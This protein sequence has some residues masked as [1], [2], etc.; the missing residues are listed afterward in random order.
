[1]AGF[2]AE[3]L[4]V[5]TVLDELRV[6]AFNGETLRFGEGAGPTVVRFDG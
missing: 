3:L 6:F 4:V 5:F 2:V 1:M